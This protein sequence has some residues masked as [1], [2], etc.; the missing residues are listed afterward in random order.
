M[1]AKYINKTMNGLTKNH[2]YVIMLKEPSKRIYVY[3]CH[4]IFDAT[5][6][7][8]M[9]MWISYASE[10]SIKRN[11]EYDKLEFEL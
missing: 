1:Q 10:K 2:E 9:D 11:W 3:D 6:K 4:I 7:E 8:E 5:K